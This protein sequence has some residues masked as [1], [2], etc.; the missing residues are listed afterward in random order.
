MNSFQLKTMK[1]L[2]F[3]VNLLKSK[4]N[5]ELF[6]SSLIQLKQKCKKIYLFNKLKR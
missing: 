3:E 2:L 6:M 1:Y 5:L 4:Q